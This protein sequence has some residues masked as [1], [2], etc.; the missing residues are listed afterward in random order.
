VNRRRHPLA[1]V[2]RALLALLAL[3]ALSACARGDAAP[4][5]PSATIDDTFVVVT[6]TPG[7][8]AR[9][10][11][12][13]AGTRTYVVEPGDTLSSI[14]A[15]FGVSEEALIQANGVTDPDTI[16]AGQVLVIPPAEDAETE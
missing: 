13:P 4:P 16:Q 6:P 14:A 5:T 2:P 8:P 12:A 11:P 9:R 15:R 1:P 7:A 3:L 10:T